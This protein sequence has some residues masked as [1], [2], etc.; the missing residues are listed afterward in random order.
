M[1]LSFRE[2]AG[3]DRRGNG[4]RH[5][6][7]RLAQRCAT[8]RISFPERPDDSR[9]PARRQLP[10]S[11]L[12]ARSDSLAVRTAG[13]DHRDQTPDRRLV[14]HAP[15]PSSS[16]SSSGIQ[17]QRRAHLLG[18]RPGPSGSFAGRCRVR[19]VARAARRQTRPFFVSC[20]SS[21]RCFAGVS[22][23]ASA[24]AERL[25]RRGLYRRRG[26]DLDEEASETVVSE[27]KEAGRSRPSASRASSAEHADSSAAPNERRF[28]GPLSRRPRRAV[29]RKKLR[30]GS[31]PSRIRPFLSQRSRRLDVGRNG[32][33]RS[34]TSRGYEVVGADRS[35]SMLRFTRARHRCASS[36][37]TGAR[38]R[39]NVRRGRPFAIAVVP[40]NS[41]H[42]ASSGAAHLRPSGLLI[43]DVWFGTPQAGGFGS[44]TPRTVA[45]N[46]WE[47]WGTLARDPLE[48]RS[49][50]RAHAPREANR[51]SLERHTTCTTSRR[52]SSSLR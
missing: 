16:K 37:Q 4:P 25:S 39:Q 46:R 22:F 35:A 40:D 7:A 28:S 49:R 21:P 12:R 27:L 38:S 33:P 47:R 1:I 52:S 13:R 19:S 48:Q 20:T 51:W 26:L 9:R 44:N 8:R 42:I 10:M 14:P 43:A 11:G 24:T 2:Q 34:A 32:T 5:G 23:T 36:K 17:P 31:E 41:D 15:C 6:S 45:E 50:L 3:D 29:R 30:G 18:E